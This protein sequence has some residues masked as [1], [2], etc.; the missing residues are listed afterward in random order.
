MIST[1]S[2]INSIFSDVL[3]KQQGVVVYLIRSPKKKFVLKL[4]A[5]CLPSQE[6]GLLTDTQKTGGGGK[7]EKQ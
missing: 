2:K 7:G 6:S 3:E 1:L 4:K 5:A